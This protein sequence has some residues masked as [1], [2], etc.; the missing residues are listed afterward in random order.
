MKSPK[1]V[2][3]GETYDV[4]C[5]KIDSVIIP[6]VLPAH[7]DGAEHC[8]Q[9]TP[10]HYHVDHRFTYL[11]H[12]IIGYDSCGDVFNH[13][14]VGLKG[15]NE[16]L[17]EFKQVAFHF[18]NRWHRTHSE[19]TAKDGICPHKGVRITNRCGTC[20]AHGLIWDLKTEKL[21]YKPPFYIQ[22]MPD[23]PKGIIDEN[24]QC[25]IEV[26]K[27]FKFN[28]TA[29]MVDSNGERYGKWIQDLNYVN[30]K[31]GTLTF[32]VSELCSK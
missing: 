23:G 15:Y 26:D 2:V 7:T 16:T 11:S 6:V 12:Q 31:C 13:R 29:I 24:D 8:L 14:M 21:K 20:P 10:K 4:P 27:L 25:A 28:G 1:N 32:D 22:L 30:L 18:V 5:V 19:L 17:G 9:E 3:V